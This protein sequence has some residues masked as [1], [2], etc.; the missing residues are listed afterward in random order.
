MSNDYFFFLLS[1]ILGDILFIVKVTLF[2]V[3]FRPLCQG[4]TQHLVSLHEMKLVNSYTCSPL[5]TND[6]V[7]H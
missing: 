6:G 7:Y 4:V 1:N 3:F 2:F 5:T